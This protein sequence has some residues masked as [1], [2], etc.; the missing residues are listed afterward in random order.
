M[1]VTTAD[2]S[3]KVLPARSAFSQECCE[4]MSIKQFRTLS[5]GIPPF[6]AISTPQ[7][8]RSSSSMLWHPG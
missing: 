8:V 2:L 6:L 4:A 1:H 5:G 3:L 7:D